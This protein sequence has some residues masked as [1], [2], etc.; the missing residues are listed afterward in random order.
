MGQVVQDSYQSGG[1]TTEATV[2]SLKLSEIY[3]IL[4]GMK[5]VINEYRGHRARAI[6][7]A[8]PQLIPA[9]VEMQVYPTK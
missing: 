3:D 5:K 8:Y 1:R 6:L 9:L 2:A 4:E 7:E